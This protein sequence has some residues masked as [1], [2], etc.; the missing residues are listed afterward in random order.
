VSLRKVLTDRVS[1]GCY[2]TRN[3]KVACPESHGLV[4]ADATMGS[5]RYCCDY[6]HRV[7]WDGNYPW[8]G[9]DH[10][11]CHNLAEILTWSTQ[12]LLFSGDFSIDSSRKL[13]TQ[14]SLMRWAGKS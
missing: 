11:E 2:F 5:G 1:F 7:S 6:I 3:T 12:T 9:K 8:G 4:V 13:G 14:V 10:G